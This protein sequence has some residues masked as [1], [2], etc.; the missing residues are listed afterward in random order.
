MNMAKKEIGV[1]VSMMLV[2]ILI[3]M[4]SVTV[5]SAVTTSISFHPLLSESSGK[6]L[7]IG[8]HTVF[9]HVHLLSSNVVGWVIADGHIHRYRGA[10]PLDS[11]NF[12]GFI[13]KNYFV[14]VFEN[15]SFQ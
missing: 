5:C 3:P 7:F 13:G 9:S 14:L 1:V 12:Y 4:T 2:G 10:L 11:R 15:N 8:K 6:T